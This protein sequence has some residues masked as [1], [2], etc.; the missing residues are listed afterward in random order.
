M[1]KNLETMIKF[2]E[3]EMGKENLNLTS[4]ASIFDWIDYASNSLDFGIS[5]HKLD[6]DAYNA[7]QQIPI[8]INNLITIRDVEG[9]TQSEITKINNRITFMNIVETTLQGIRT[10]ISNA[11]PDLKFTPDNTEE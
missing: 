3:T 1:F 4:L 9:R 7:I 5:I 11:L 10:Q 8:M 6:K 2:Y